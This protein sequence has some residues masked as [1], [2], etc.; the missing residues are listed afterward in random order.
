MKEQEY[1]FYQLNKFFP[2]FYFSLLYLYGIKYL[3]F[4]CIDRIGMEQFP[5]LKKLIGVTIPIF[6]EQFKILGVR[7]YPLLF[8]IGSY[9]LFLSIIKKR[10]HREREVFYI[11]S[12]FLLLPGTIISTLIVNKGAVLLFLTFLIFK[13]YLEGYRFLTITLLLLYPLVDR[14]MLTLLTGFLVYAL[15]Q[16]NWRL[17]LVTTIGLAENLYF[18][19]LHIGGIPRNHFTTLLLTYSA[20]YSPLPFF[21]FLY[22]LYRTTLN[23]RK[24]IIYFITASAFILSLL[25]SF[26]QRIQIDDY[27]PFTLPFIVYLIQQFLTSYRVRLKPFRQGY[28]WL[29]IGMFCSILFTDLMLFLNP[30]RNEIGSSY[31]FTKG[32]ANRIEREY[33]C[34]PICSNQ[35]LCSALRFYSSKIEPSLPSCSIFYSKR[36]GEVEIEF[37]STGQRVKKTIP[38]SQLTTP[39]F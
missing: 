3:N 12:L 37:N 25:L 30:F 4:S 11:G 13:F 9:L 19:P 18:Y 32:L 34:F 2:I 27:A 24:G 33:H 38:I 31:Y 35:F 8:S 7:L 28:R 1:F 6:A 39:N 23:N 21:Y 16:K 26:R 36:K 15:W 20:I 5:I 17:G 29:F 22:T 10:F 14:A